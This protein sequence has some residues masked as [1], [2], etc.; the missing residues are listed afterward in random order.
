MVHCF[1]ISFAMAMK[2]LREHVQRPL[3]PL[4]GAP[5]PMHRGIGVVESLNPIAGKRSNVNSFAAYME[6]IPKDKRGARRPAS[7]TAPT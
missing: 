2:Q 5:L 3:E 4:R 6:G 1:A 7:L